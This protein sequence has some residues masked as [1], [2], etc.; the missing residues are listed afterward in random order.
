[1]P[2]VARRGSTPRRCSART[3]AAVPAAPPKGAAVATALPTS[4]VDAMSASDGLPV[5]VVVDQQSL[6]HPGEV[7]HQELRGDERDQ[8]PPVDVD[9]LV[10]G[11]E[12]TE[13]RRRE[14]VDDAAAEDPRHALAHH[15]TDRGAVD[16]AAA[17]R[18]QACRCTAALRPARPSRRQERSQAWRRPGKKRKEQRAV[19]RDRTGR[20]GWERYRGRFPPASI[21][22][23]SA[24]IVPS[25]TSE[26]SDVADDLTAKSYP[27]TSTQDRCSEDDRMASTTA[28]LATPST[29]VPAAGS[30]ATASP[31]DAVAHHLVE[32]GVGRQVH[33]ARVPHVVGGVQQLARRRH[34]RDRG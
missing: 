1:M 19:P 29:K 5:H 30:S 8:P 3:C 33:P 13:D 7:E 4:C 10:R 23:P 11:R 16:P 20:W 32:A 21:G 2:D 12:H 22:G 14:Q 17:A 15:A 31:E 27:D 18:V 26:R 6:Q 25:L 34:R 28:W 9:Q 24:V